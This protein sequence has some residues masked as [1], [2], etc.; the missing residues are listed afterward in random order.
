MRLLFAGTPE[1]AV[2]SLEALL[3]SGHEVVGVI[4]RPDA[5]KGR[6][7]SLH[8]SEVGE[9]ADHAGIPVLTPRTLRD[10]AAHAEITA[11]GADAA[12]VVAYGNLIPPA[13]L[14]AFPW[15]NLHF[16]LLPRWR[17][18]A[19]VQRAIAAG[20]VETGACAFLLEE[21]LDTGPVLARM[22]RPIGDRETAGDVLGDLSVRGASLLVAAM[23]LL[24]DGSARPEPQSDDGVTLA[25]KVEVAEARVDWAAPS[26]EI[27]RRVRAFTPEPGSWTRLTDG[28]RV[29]IGPLFPGESPGPPPGEMLVEKNR[30][31]VGTGS[32][33]VRLGDVAPAGKNWMDAAA[34]SRGLRGEF[35]FEIDGRGQ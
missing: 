35:S 32:G 24:A 2:P 17:G 3:A 5:R 9:A 31:L 8:R 19:P 34:W 29:K 23:D 10:P 33:T 18:A 28:T 25:P 7:R 14:E 1:P 15:V 22:T 4:T 13:L 16:S 12:A 11:L 26:T 6:G 21:G 30:V 20:D 27:D